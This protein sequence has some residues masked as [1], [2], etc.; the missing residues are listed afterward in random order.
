MPPPFRRQNKRREIMETKTNK[1]PVSLKTVIICGAVGLVIAIAL[2]VGTA[3]AL[4]YENLLTVFF[5]GSSYSVT[6]AEKELCEEIEAEGIVLL[7]NEDN[8][9]PLTEEET[10]VAVLGQ[11]AVDFVYGGAGS[12][13]VD[14]SLAPTFR[15]ALERAGFTVNDT[16]WSF[17]ASGAGSSYRKTYPN[18]SGDG[19]FAVNEVPRSVFTNTEISSM[20]GDD[21]GIVVIGRSGGESSDLPLETLPT[22]YKYLQVDGNERDTISL[23]CSKFDKVVLIVNSSNPLELGFLE[24][25]EFSNVKAALWVGAV[26]QEGMYA[27]G[28]VLSGDVNP[29]GRLVD[30]YAY[31]S[32]SAP[33]AKNMGDFSFTNSTVTNGNK[34]IVYQ[35]GIYVGYRYYET[36]YEDVVLGSENAGDYDYAEQVQYP[37]GYGL[38]YA[39]FSWSGFGMTENAES[40]EISVT[41]TNNGDLSGKEVVQIYMQSP[42]TEYDRSEHIEKSSVEL[43]G[44][45]KTDLIGPGE[46]KTVT[47]EVPKELMKTYDAHGAGTYIVDAG[48]YY[49]TAAA[50]AHDAVNNILMAKGVTAE[51]QSRMSGTG[52][53][54][55]TADYVQAERDVETYSVS[56]ATGAKIVNRFGDADA[57]KYDDCTYLT[58][59]DWTGTMPAGAYKDGSWQASS[60]LLADLEWYRADEVTDADG[61]TMPEFG[62]TDTAYTVQEL[63][64]ADYGDARWNDLISQLS[65]TQATRLVRMGG[66]ST[67]QIDVIGLPATQDKDGPSGFSNTLVGGVAT[68]AWPAEVVLASTWNTSI[69]E[70]MGKG[71]GD[72][73]IAAG[74]TGWYA[75]GVNIHRSPYSG[76]NFEYY[77]EDGFLSGKIG[78]AEMR[79]VRSKGVIAYMKHFALNDQETNRYGGAVFANE[80]SIREIWLKG[81]ELTAVEGGANAAME[82]MNR[83]GARW[84]GAHKGLMTDVL[85]GEWGFE[86]MVITDQASVSAMFYQDMISGLW[87]GTDIWL[88]TNSAYW[89]LD[90]YRDNP[91]VMNNVFRAAKNIVYSITNSNAV[92]DY[93]SGGL[94]DTDFGM[95]AWKIIMII[96]DVVLFAGCASAIAVPLTLYLIGR[97][98][99]DP[100][101]NRS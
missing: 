87:A 37:F 19:A 85:R 80:Q 58:R 63:V 26:G 69:I 89:S 93:E 91:T 41:V 4:R 95:P 16:L 57:N 66:Y 94:A 12:G 36:R 17:Y 18:E 77:S 31:D 48:T 53:A 29:S 21:V 82:G 42:Y 100:A 97:K 25:E 70:D 74:V 61:A 59:Y 14:S 54:S 50:N 64:D 65:V 30:T 78:A 20:D 84:A 47:V 49:F 15:Q 10:N 52:D 22:G 51:Q 79:G 68:M 86:G 9:L 6:E 3:F 44:F 72:Q 101:G 90:D 40:F 99:G 60:E 88:N 28:E 24:E 56:S 45:A 76:R 83:I 73:S 96:L 98:R 92:Q 71:L 55:F 5:S 75:P 35:E 67:I 27:I 39:D 43:V 13:S 33:S 1:K 23:A 32:Q 38:S 81:F 62:S 8:A 46:S 7:K 34:Y 11:D 2:I